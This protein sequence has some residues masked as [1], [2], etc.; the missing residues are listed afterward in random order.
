[1]SLLRRGRARVHHE[2]ARG[3]APA[4]SQLADI[5]SRRARAADTAM[6]PVTASLASGT[7]DSASSASLG[8]SSA[9]DDSH[10]QYEHSPPTSPRSTTAT[11]SPARAAMSA[12]F[13]PAVP[14]PITRPSWIE[15]GF[16][17]SLP[18]LDGHNDWNRPER[19]PSDFVGK[20]AN[21]GTSG[22]A[23]QTPG[24]GPGRDLEKDRGLFDLVG[25]FQLRLVRCLHG[26]EGQTF[27][28]LGVNIDQD[29]RTGGELFVEHFLR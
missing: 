5:A 23:E 10:A 4:S 24:H 13:S 18:S 9:F 2:I 27:R 1:M 26:G 7:R 22:W 14:P 6:A 29:R 15:S 12:A 16:L 20:A 8:H 28:I 11:R 17:V 19:Q 3:T 21:R 25:H